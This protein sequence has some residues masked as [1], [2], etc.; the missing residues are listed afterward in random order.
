V[1][2]NEPADSNA[3]FLGLTG[4][5]RIARAPS[6]NR[7]V[8]SQAWEEAVLKS[9][10]VA[11]IGAVLLISLPGISDAAPPDGS[12]SAYVVAAVEMLN[13]DKNRAGQGYGSRSFTEDLKF[14]DNGTLK[15]SGA[16][17]TMC[18]AAQLEVLVEAFNAYS[19]QTGDYKPFHFIPKV[20]WERL[21]PL[22]LRGMIWMVK[23]SQST[24]AAYAFEHFGMGKRLPFKDLFPGTFINFN[25]TNKSG[26]GG[27]FLGFIDKDGNDLAVYSGAVAGFKY[28]SAQGA[29]KP[30]PISGL[31]K[32]WAFFSD[33]GCPSNLPDGHLRDCGI[34]RSEE[35]G[36]LVGGYVSIPTDWDKD[37]ANGAVLTDNDATVPELTTEGTFDAAFFTGVTTD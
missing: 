10:C 22:D 19:A 5:K 30:K 15:A 7:L 14:G 32:R 12:F 2:W 36:L 1:V 31:G 26:H 8:V 6:V 18:V 29:K 34:I 37:K 21:R 33:A 20:F 3:R 24:G 27:V 28:F 9:I 13:S 25:R 4:I 11:F 16:P 23:N 35:H 17:L